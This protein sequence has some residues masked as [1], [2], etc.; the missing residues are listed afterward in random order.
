[1]WKVVK[2]VAI[3]VAIVT[4]V[5]FLIFFAVYVFRNTGGGSGSGGAAKP[6][7]WGSCAYQGKFRTWQGG[8]G[9]V[10]M[11]RDGAE[12]LLNAMD[13]KGGGSRVMK[14]TDAE[15]TRIDQDN[16]YSGRGAA[17]AKLARQSPVLQ[18]REARRERSNEDFVTLQFTDGDVYFPPSL[19]IHVCV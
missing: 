4:F 7:I 13:A 5:A 8:H 3:T 1:M 14:I 9:E 17:I 12:T 19:F 18:V 16:P 10:R 2:F 15:S 6:T 11:L